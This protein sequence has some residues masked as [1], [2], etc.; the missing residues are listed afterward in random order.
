MNK[1]SIGTHP[2]ANTEET[3]ITVPTGQVAIVHMIMMSNHTGN[4]KLGSLWW[5]HGHD[6]THDIY[7]VDDK[8]FT[9]AELLN[10]SDIELVMREGDKL[11]VMT[12]A[13]SDFS[14]IVTF[15]LFP[16]N[17]VTSNFNI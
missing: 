12:E 5:E 16:D 15:D 14:I 11:K 2:L 9:S 13:G 1:F 4:N 8:N 3:I 17:T 7:I 6:A 10:L